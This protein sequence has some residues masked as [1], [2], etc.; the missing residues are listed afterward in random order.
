MSVQQTVQQTTK[1]WISLKSIL[2]SVAIRHGITNGVRDAGPAALT[3]GNWRATIRQ[4]YI[5]I[6]I[7]ANIFYSISSAA[8]PPH[9]ASPCPYPCSPTAKSSYPTLFHS[10]CAPHEIH[11]QNNSPPSWYRIRSTCASPSHTACWLTSFFVLKGIAVAYQSWNPVRADELSNAQAPGVSTV[12]PSGQKLVS[13]EEVQK[14]NK[15][16]DCWVIIDVREQ[17]ISKSFAE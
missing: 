17:P 8:S 16:E 5:H 10:F 1:W 4:K 9:D 12:Q 15:R 7:P 14:H 6:S 2:L 11:L 13:F 3:G